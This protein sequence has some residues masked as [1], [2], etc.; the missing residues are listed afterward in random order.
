MASISE[1]KK[2]FTISLTLHKTFSGLVDRL[3]QRK[4]FDIEFFCKN[5]IVLIEVYF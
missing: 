1:E 2:S 4:K 5:V 3:F